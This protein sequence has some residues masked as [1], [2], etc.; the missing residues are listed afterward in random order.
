MSHVVATTVERKALRQFFRYAYIYIY[1]FVSALIVKA[2]VIIRVP[3]GN[4]T[5][6]DVRAT[7]SAGPTSTPPF[8]FSYFLFYWYFGLAVDGHWFNSLQR[9]GRGD[10]APFPSLQKWKTD[11]E[12][13]K[14]MNWSTFW[15]DR[16]EGS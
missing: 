13:P 14:T 2:E 3:K 5:L 10:A 16:Q 6:R 4:I 9:T 7:C 8:F 15:A 1:I 11:F 12:A